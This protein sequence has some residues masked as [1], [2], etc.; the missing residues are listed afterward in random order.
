M[1][2]APSRKVS[3]GNKP[4]PPPPPSPE[5]PNNQGQK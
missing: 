2:T 4:L 1:S 3:K 5:E